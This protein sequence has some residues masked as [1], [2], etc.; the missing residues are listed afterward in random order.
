MVLKKGLASKRS[1]KRFTKPMIM[2]ISPAHR[3]SRREPPNTSA[4]P[5][6]PRKLPRYATA[7]RYTRHRAMVCRSHSEASSTVG[8]S[9]QMR[10]LRAFSC[11]SASRSLP[12]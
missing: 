1:R 4:K 3:Q 12:W 6:P 7:G 11:S 9:R 5:S 10:R 8:F 2:P